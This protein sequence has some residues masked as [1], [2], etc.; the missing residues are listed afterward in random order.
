[1]EDVR[2]FV[3]AAADGDRS[4]VAAFLDRY[5]DHCVD[6][7]RGEPIN[8]TALFWCVQVGNTAG[9]EALLD[10]GAAIERRDSE[11]CTPLLVAARQGH[12]KAVKLL[13]ER[14][15]DP[16]AV[17]AKGRGA[18]ALAQGRN[19]PEVEKLVDDA[20]TA[21]REA[22]EAVALAAKNARDQAA[23]SFQDTMRR[24]A[25]RYRVKPAKRGPGRGGPS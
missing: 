5:G 11:G 13:L 19:S 7:T 10:R 15:A 16:E 21:R 22:R 2:R 24:N 14:G 4:A 17:D 25:G 23:D 18:P 1:M 8:W 9:I 6:V 20:V 3:N 12:I